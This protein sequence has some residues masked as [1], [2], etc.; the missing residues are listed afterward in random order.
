MEYIKNIIFDFGGVIYRIN[1]HL[2]FEKFSELSKYPDL[3]HNK[4]QNF[5]TTKIFLDYQNGL[6]NSHEFRIK[7]KELFSLDISDNEFDKAWNRTLVGID[8]QSNEL[9]TNIKNKY[10]IALL[11][12]TNEIHYNYFINECESI[13]NK[14][15]FL[16][17][18]H[19][20][21]LS[22]PSIEIY[23]YLIDKTK[24][25][26]EQTLF[27]DDSKDNIDSAKKMGFRTILLKKNN[28]NELIKIFHISNHSN[29]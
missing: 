11:S 28:L 16:F 4:V 8:P 20:I 19:I 29:K 15:D 2:A 7:S 9:I 17:F 27:I 1:E 10:R 5:I 24:F 3:F 12:N 14:F 23:E 25:R 22:K 26:I 18:S 13:F 21:H 6:I